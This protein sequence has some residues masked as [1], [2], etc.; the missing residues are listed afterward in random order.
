MSYVIKMIEFLYFFVRTLIR[1]YK[2]IELKILSLFPGFIERTM[3]KKLYKIGVV[4]ESSEIKNKNYANIL[5]SSKYDKLCRLQLKDKQILTKIANRGYIAMGEGYVNGDFEVTDDLNDI[6][7]FIT[8]CLT[9][10]YYEYYFNFWNRLHHKLEFESFNLQTIPRAWE[11][12]RKH[13]D[14]GKLFYSRQ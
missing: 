7:E 8:R 2:W 11:V 6:T 5:Q 9:N 14:L 4:L 1:I 3:K 13:Y 10:N 12:G